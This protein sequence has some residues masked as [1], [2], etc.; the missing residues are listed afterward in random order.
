MDSLAERLASIRAEQDQNRKNLRVAEIVSELF[1]AA[2]TAPVIVGG[3][4]VEFYTDG[5]YVSAD[6]DVCF[7]G[8]RLPT[9]RERESVL[10]EAGTSLGLRTWQIADVVVDLLGVIETS[11]Q[12][13]F[14]N[15]G[16]LTLIQIEDLIAERILVA[17]TPRFDSERW[18][19][20]KV[21]FAVALQRLVAFDPVELERIANSPDY[22]VGPDLQRLRREIEAQPSK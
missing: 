13:P 7:S 4:A 8:A 9:P 19:V 1:R 2:G 18:R 20:A 11:A 12:T 3:S 17:T 10:A 15:L 6:V 16:T 5:A 22:R 14:Q 21:L